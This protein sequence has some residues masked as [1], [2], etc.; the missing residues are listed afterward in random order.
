MG[1]AEGRVY[2]VGVKDKGKIYKILLLSF[3][4]M[5]HKEGII[6]RLEQNKERIRQFG[7]QKITLFG[8]YAR[9]EADRN[10][11]MDFLVQFEEGRGLYDDYSGLLSFLHSLFKVKIDVVKPS[12][13]REELREEIFG[14]IQIEAK[15]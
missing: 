15:V 10:S 3:K 7:V 11:D 6:Q 5:M 4:I 9:D 1:V 13:V 12:L 8:S 2:W 14:G